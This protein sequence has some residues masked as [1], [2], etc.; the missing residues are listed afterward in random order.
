M[1]AGGKSLEFLQD[2]QQAMTSATSMWESKTWIYSR[3]L[4]RV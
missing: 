4:S 3:K 2:A 1:W